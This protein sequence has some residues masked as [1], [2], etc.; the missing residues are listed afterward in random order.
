[1]TFKF[2]ELHTVCAYHEPVNWLDHFAENSLR[3]AHSFIIH[4]EI[5]I[6]GTETYVFKQISR[7]TMVY[8]QPRNCRCSRQ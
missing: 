6:K 4:I 7:C 8:W 3:K 1:M 5:I 2:L